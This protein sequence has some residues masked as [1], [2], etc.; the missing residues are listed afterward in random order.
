MANQCRDE[1]E[2][3]RSRGNNTRKFDMRIEVKRERKAQ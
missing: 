1:S 2:V 3:H